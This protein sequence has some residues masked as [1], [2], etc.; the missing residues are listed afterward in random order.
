M[1]DMTALVTKYQDNTQ[2]PKMIGTGGGMD[3]LVIAKNPKTGLQLGIKTLVGQGVVEGKTAILVGFRLRSAYIPGADMG[4]IV[5]LGGE[6]IEASEVTDK[7]QP[8]EGY[9][10]AW[11]NVGNSP[12]GDRA[13]L[14]R[15][16]ALNRTPE[17]AKWVYDDLDHIRFFGKLQAMLHEHVPD[18]QWV[19][20][21]DDLSDYIRA[22]IYPTLTGM[23][24]QHDP[25]KMLEFLKLQKSQHSNALDEKIKALEAQVEAKPAED[26]VYHP[27]AH[28]GDDELVPMDSVAHSMLKGAKPKLGVVA[29]GGLV[30]AADDE[31][32]MAEANEI[33]QGL[34]ASGISFA[35][36][37]T[38]VA[39][40]E[41]GEGDD[42]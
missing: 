30:S 41:D 7:K 11:E 37:E 35:S 21:D 23:E 4:T 39:D 28:F 24:A 15:T 12:T 25:A 6:T 27:K 3:Y 17:E 5:G 16:V 14:I 18:E 9:P 20:T 10:F 19:I 34:G 8:H 32:M 42:D 2:F 38:M 22:S 40:A 29:S 31:A 33:A 36:E 26:E 13:S 1:K